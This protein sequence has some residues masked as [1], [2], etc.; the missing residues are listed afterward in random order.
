MSDLEFR[1]SLMAMGVQFGVADPTP[2]LEVPERRG[3]QFFK[4]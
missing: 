1:S 3:S 4:P 2:N